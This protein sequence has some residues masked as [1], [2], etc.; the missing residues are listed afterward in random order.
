L[1]LTREAFSQQ[2]LIASAQIV[3][4]EANYLRDSLPHYRSGEQ[5]DVLLLT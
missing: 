2:R 4:E 1:Q 3:K 5:Q